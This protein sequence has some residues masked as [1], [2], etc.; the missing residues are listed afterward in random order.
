MLISTA[1]FE[2]SDIPRKANKPELANALRTM[3]E[4]L[5]LGPRP[6]DDVKFILDGGALL[7]ILPWQIC[8]T[9]T[10]LFHLYYDYVHARYGDAI[11]VF[12]EYPNY[13]TIKDS[14]HARRCN[15]I[16]KEVI[17]ASDMKMKMKK[18]VFLSCKSNKAK[19]IAHLA[20]EV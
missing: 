16:G 10:E 5:S 1:L 8:S 2:S 7:H 6:T 19:F 4:L 15:V 9:Y 3:C 12:D 11:V 20:A 14:T 17:Y 18:E 13:P